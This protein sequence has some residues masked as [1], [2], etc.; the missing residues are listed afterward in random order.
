[1]L[2]EQCDKY[3][4]MVEFLEEE[5]KKREI[6]ISP[7]ERNL[8]SIAY[9]NNINNTRSALRTIMAYESKEKKKENSSFLPY[10]LFY[11]KEIS[12]KLLDQYQRTIKFVEDYLINKAKDNE[13]IVFYK[14]MIGDY[15]RYIEESVFIIKNQ[16]TNDALK[17]YEEAKEKAE[18]LPI[19]N[20]I[21]LGLYINLSVFY[22][23]II[24]DHKKAI[25][26]TKSI[27]EEAEKE[28]PYIDEDADENRDTISI[29]N[30]LKENLE[31]WS[32][33]CEN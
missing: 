13:A 23:D 22:Y 7:D 15:N 9:K 29:Y 24:N 30:L 8:L 21:K 33:K 6:D 20:P 32:M 17:Y 19:L 11:K 5:F 27:I 16:A 18:E 4:E 31:D 26:I 1:M 12:N 3:E 2:A 14:K 10:I 28:L 25:D